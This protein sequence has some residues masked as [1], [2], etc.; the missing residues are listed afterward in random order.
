MVEYHHGI[1]QIIIINKNEKHE[2]LHP[3]YFAEPA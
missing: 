2:D 1:Q 3:Y